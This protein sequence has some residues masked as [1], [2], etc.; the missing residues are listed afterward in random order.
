[1]A[2]LDSFQIYDIKMHGVRLPEFKITD[3]FRKEFGVPFKASNYDFLKALA[4]KGF[5]TRLKL[6]KSS[7]LYKEYVKRGKYELETFSDLGFIDYVL[8]VWDILHFCR[9]NNIPTGAGR[10]SCCG[11]LILYLIGVTEIDPIKHSLYFERF[12]SKMR[13]KK[14]IVGG[15]TYL[16]GKLLMDVDMDISFEERPKV[17]EYVQTKYAGRTSKILTYNTL[18]GKILIKEC[19]KII[20]ELTESEVQEASNMIPRIFG[21]VKD[22]EETNTKDKTFKEWCDSHPE[23]YQTALKLRELIRNKGTHASGYV[24]SYDPIAD[25]CPLE[26]SSD[27]EVV[28]GYDMEWMN[29][30][31]V[32]L[33]LLGLREVS[34]VHDVCKQLN[35]S[36][37]DIDPNDPIIYQKLQDLDLE[38][39]LFQIK[40]ECNYRVLKKVKP[41]NLEELSGVLALG[42]PGALDFVDQY[43]AYTNTGEF[44]SV[45]EFFDD[46]LKET[47]GV[48]LFQEQLMKMA[49]KIGFSLD[50]AEI[51]RRIVGK[52]KLTE[53]KEWKS[54]ISEKVKENNLPKEV[55]EILWKVLEDSASYSF[56][57]SHSVAYATLS[58]LTVYLKFKYPKQYYLS[59]LKM[60][61]YQQDP[62]SEISC[63]HR[64]MNAFGI[65]LMP[66]HLLKSELDFS[67]EGDGIRFGLL[68]IKGISDKSIEK[69]NQF[70]NKHANKFQLFQAAK[71]AKLSIG[72]L[73]AL[74]QAGALE[75]LSQT[76]SKTVLEAQLWYILN[77]K[78]RGLCLKLGEESKFDLI[79]VLRKAQKAKD[80]KG[81]PIVKES[82][83][84]TIRNRY[85]PYR[86][87]QQMNS[88]NEDFANW[89]YEKTLLGYTYN[90]KLID[91]FRKAIGYLLPISEIKDRPENEAVYYIG[92]IE[93]V[94]ESV[95]KN[96]N[97]Y[98]KFIVSD[99]TGVATTFLFNNKLEEHKQENGNKAAEEGTIVIVKGKR[100]GDIVFGDYLNVQNNKIYMRLSELKDD[101]EPVGAPQ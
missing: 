14:T 61:K 80:E 50:E 95:S 34:L 42:R 11:S 23:V 28:T 81:R 15:V 82:R 30:L 4:E 52:K 12:V 58:A 67:M 41:K 7:D 24:V 33:D 56:N 59:L 92:T 94:Y 71:Q 9:T 39:G 13:A 2:F 37:S 91:I 46:I 22:I 16:D 53:V 77:E 75:G 87:I 31:A 85:E 74:I 44:Q 8:M 73:S 49:H 54:K 55:G 90:I 98:G 62:I 64:E 21:T 76:R 57:K 32:K 35:I 72:I 45:H 70:R 97:P 26:L 18:T 93:K 19:G 79:E 86:K 60:S 65:K 84:G 38:H 10:G 78:E 83:L 25:V 17:I 1:M 63:I 3:A 66:P 29:L 43:A 100:K 40:G 6:D 69:I 36:I 99:E 27:K 101:V 20:E 48:P 47:G 89:Y 51:L 68:S 88:K 5:K 96:K